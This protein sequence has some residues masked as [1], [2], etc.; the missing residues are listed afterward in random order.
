M[1]TQQQAEREEQ[2]RIK[3]LV[4]K[5]D[6]RDDNDQENGEFISLPSSYGPLST[7]NPNTKGDSG[8]ERQHP[9]HSRIDK[10]SNTRSGQR[11]RKLQMSDVDWYDSTS[12]SSRKFSSSKPSGPASQNNFQ[13]PFSRKGERTG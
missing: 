10:S 12:R 5:Y 2:Q 7:R 13:G 1:K 11:A 3:N 4:L 6:L 9:S 8:L